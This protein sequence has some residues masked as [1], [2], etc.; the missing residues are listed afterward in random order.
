MTKTPIYIQI[1]EWLR[2][3]VA[4]RPP[5]ALMPTI[6]EISHRFDVNGV[7][8]VR[9]AYQILMDDDLVERL[10]SPRRWVVIDHGQE[11]EPAPSSQDLLDELVANLERAAE[12][13]RELRL[14]T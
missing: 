11:A 5:G 10:D 1:S 4:H 2:D 14:V 7:Q 8:T 3:E 12:L 6:N 13:A 9:N